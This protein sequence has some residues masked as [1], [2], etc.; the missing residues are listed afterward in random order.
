MKAAKVFRKNMFVIPQS[1]QTTE[2]FLLCF[3]SVLP[4]IDVTWS[5]W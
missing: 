4:E 5:D 3:F 1:H 2:D